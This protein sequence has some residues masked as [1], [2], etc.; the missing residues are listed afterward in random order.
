MLVLRNYKENEIEELKELLIDEGIDDLELDGIIYVV[1]ED[2]MLIGSS[3]VIEEDG[4][5]ILQ[6]I[7]IKEEFRRQNLGDG[8][9]RAILNKLVN[10]GIKDVYFKANDPFLISRGFII[11]ENDEI[12]LDLENFFNKGCKGCEGFNEL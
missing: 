12:M 3:K 9:L 1:L 4:K 2:D 7:V 11:L 10:Q 5:W 6:Y 8:L